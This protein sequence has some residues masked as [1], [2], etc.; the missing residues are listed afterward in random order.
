MDSEEEKDAPWPPVDPPL[1]MLALLLSSRT[2]SLFAMQDEGATPTG[3]AG[4]ADFRATPRASGIGHYWPASSGRSPGTWTRA[5]GDVG[6]ITWRE[7]FRHPAQGPHAGMP[8][9]LWTRAGFHHRDHCPRPG[10]VTPT[11]WSRARTLAGHAPPEVPLP[12]EA[13]D[14]WRTV[15]P[16]GRAFVPPL[17]LGGA[18]LLLLALLIWVMR[19]RSAPSRLLRITS[20]ASYAPP[21]SSPR[22]TGADPGSATTPPRRQSMA[23]CLRREDRFALPAPPPSNGNPQSS[24]RAALR[25]C[26]DR[27]RERGPSASIPAG[28]TPEIT[29]G[30]SEGPAFAQHPTHSPHT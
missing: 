16:A 6:P 24:F 12:V 13:A 7:D 1:L 26:T 19:S 15:A 3:D 2:A 23:D 11:S 20:T 4:P 22:R 10:E 18:G 28:A 27:T 25:S 21:S 9:H 5:T 30:R 14:R 29:F 8:S 17:F